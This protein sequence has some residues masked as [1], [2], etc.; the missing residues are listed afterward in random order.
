MTANVMGSLGR[1]SI[2]TEGES[3]VLRF[4]RDHRDLKDMGRKR[5][6]FGIP[7][8]RIVQSYLSARPCI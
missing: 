2:M 7:D 5:D 8:K 1:D 3:S 6:I 4:E